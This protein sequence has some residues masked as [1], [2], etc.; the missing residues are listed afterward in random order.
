MARARR[1]CARRKNVT[2]AKPVVPTLIELPA[3]LR[4]ERVVLRPYRAADAEQVFAA[5][6]ESRD[7]IRPWLP[8]ADSHQTVDDTRDFCL[9]SAADWIL[10]TDLVLGIFDRADGRYFGGTG[11]HRPDWAL[12]SFEIGYW[13]RSTAEGRGLITESVILLSTFAFEHL[14]AN[15]VEIWC[16]ARND[17]SRAVAERAGFILEGRLRN[18]ALDTDGKPTNSLVFSRIPGDPPAA[19]P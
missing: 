8:W 16:D 18:V 1:L 13:L 6:D 2:D 5:I 11:L 7:R 3:E 12:R 10:R 14:A 9:R 15:R 4:G 19:V 17:R